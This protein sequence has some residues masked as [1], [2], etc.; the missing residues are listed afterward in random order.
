[1]YIQNDILPS[2]SVSDFGIAQPDGET[3]TIEDGVLSVYS[4]PY[5]AIL[6]DN[7]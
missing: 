2:A 6:D 5:E 3:L 7:T 1:M 4:I